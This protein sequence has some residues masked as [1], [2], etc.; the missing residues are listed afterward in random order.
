M[1]KGME[2]VRF[3]LLSSPRDRMTCTFTIKGYAKQRLT[4]SLSVVGCSEMDCHRFGFTHTKK[5]SPSST[6]IR[7]FGSRIAALSCS[8]VQCLSCF[9]VHGSCWCGSWQATSL[10]LTM[11]PQA[12]N[13]SAPMAEVLFCDQSSVLASRALINM[14][15]ANLGQLDRALA[16]WQAIPIA[17]AMA[18]ASVSPSLQAGCS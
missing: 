13:V 2:E 15:H 5:P 7:L 6:C 14:A 17:L 11:Q 4:L 3:A 8:G 16:R 18:I 1:G 10:R 9:V 12:P